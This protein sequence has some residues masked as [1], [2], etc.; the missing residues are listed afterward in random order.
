MH[1]EVAV[2]ECHENPP[3]AGEFSQQHWGKLNRF[4]S[5][6]QKTG[7]TEEK[8]WSLGRG[9]PPPYFLRRRQSHSNDTNQHT[10]SNQNSNAS[11]ALTELTTLV[12]Y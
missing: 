5:S 2:L 7:H 11:K 1:C 9:R 4:Y 6:C 12:S 10:A 3:S 8:C